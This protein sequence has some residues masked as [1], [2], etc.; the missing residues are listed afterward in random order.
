MDADQTK[1][2]F[3]ATLRNNL[4]QTLLEEVGAYG[5]LLQLLNQKQQY[6]LFNEQDDLQKLAPVEKIVS[7]KVIALT[8]AR[9]ACLKQ[10]FAS[11]GYPE[12]KRNLQ[13]LISALPEREAKQ[14]NHLR[15]RLKSLFEKSLRI[16]KQNTILQNKVFD[17]VGDWSS[18][19]RYEPRESLYL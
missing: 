15:Q 10:L 17:N 18:T 8:N 4:L 16:H 11:M 5:Y 9:K 19:E 7:G 2:G 14:W 3:E 6:I 13:T 1:N 12:E